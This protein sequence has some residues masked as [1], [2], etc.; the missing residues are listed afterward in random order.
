MSLNKNTDSDTKD[1]KGGDSGNL[2]KNSSF[3]FKELLKLSKFAYIESFL[4]GNLI[5]A[6]I[7]KERFIERLEKNK[8][9]LRNNAIFLKIVSAFFLLMLNLFFIMSLQQLNKGLYTITEAN[10]NLYAFAFSTNLAIQYTLQ[11]IFMFT[12]G[13]TMMLGFFSG[14]SFRFLNVLPLNKKDTSKIL[15]LAF[16]RTID[17]QLIVLIFAQPIISLIF[18]R[19]FQSF[20]VLLINSFVVM[21]FFISLMVIFSNFLSKRVFN[22]KRLSKN[23]NMLRILV[24]LGYIFVLMF[25]SLGISYFI[26]KSANFFVSNIAQGDSGFMINFSL[27]FFIFPFSPAYFNLLG[28]IPF[29]VSTP[30]LMTILKFIPGYLLFCLLTYLL[31]K[32]ALYILGNLPKEELKPMKWVRGRGRYYIRAGRTTAPQ[33]KAS[34]KDG[35]TQT[36]TQTQTQTTISVTIL[37]VQ[38]AMLK[39]DFKNIFRSFNLILYF[40]FPIIY[41]LIGLFSVIKLSDNYFLFIE[42]FQIIFIIYFGM[43][44]VFSLMVATGTENESAGLLYTLPISNYEIFKSKRKIMLINI[45]LGNIVAFAVIFILCDIITYGLYTLFILANNIIL[46]ISLVDIALIL[47]ARLFGRVKNKYTLFKVNYANKTAKAVI[48]V[49]IIYAISIAIF[50]LYML[51]NIYINGPDLIGLSQILPLNLLSIHALPLSL[52]LIANVMLLIISEILA[53]RI[54]NK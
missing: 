2:T 31:Y 21:V 8:N 15:T 19:S 47:Y 50:L 3:T 10:I 53:S 30:I 20:V 23:G 24:S 14:K 4:E 54:F 9:S 26:E 51:T 17:Y 11:F 49:A 36:Q 12:Y 33:S 22:E 48:G 44:V 1:I 25:S 46:S 37:P 41:P 34:L 28:V 35:S 5:V 7:E 42:T 32:K 18:I 6:G 52:T 13:L 16:I 39:K 38:K 29:S 45:I 43:M 40:I 27:S